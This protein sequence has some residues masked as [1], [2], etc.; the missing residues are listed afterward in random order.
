MRLD[1]E[2]ATADDADR[3]SSGRRMRVHPGWEDV[4]SFAIEKMNP[5]LKTC[6]IALGSIILIALFLSISPGGFPVDEYYEGPNGS[7]LP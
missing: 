6:L 1:P 4:Y 2:M 7:E 3:G 5:L